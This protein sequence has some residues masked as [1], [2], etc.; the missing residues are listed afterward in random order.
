MVSYH[1]I[2]MPNVIV[3]YQ[4]ISSQCA[5]KFLFLVKFWPNFGSLSFYLHW[6][7]KTHILIQVAL[8]IGTYAHEKSLRLK[9]YFWRDS[10]FIEQSQIFS[11]LLPNP[12]HPNFS[13]LIAWGKT[14]FPFLKSLYFQFYSM[15]LIFSC[16]VIFPW[17]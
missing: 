3:K 16:R 14:T 5:L 15:Q 7:N 2:V 11:D 1:Y 8:I 4:S 12:V 17:I 6:T 13:S 10:L 9:K